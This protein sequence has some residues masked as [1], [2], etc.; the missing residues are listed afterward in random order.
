MLKDLTEEI[1]EFLNE[2][3]GKLRKRKNTIYFRE[4]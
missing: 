4:N 2:I 3:K 1:K